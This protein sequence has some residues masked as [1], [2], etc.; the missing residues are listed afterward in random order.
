[1]GYYSVELATAYYHTYVPTS[2][3]GRPATVL[4]ARQSWTLFYHVHPGAWPWPRRT[5]VN[6]SY[7]DSRTDALVSPNIEVSF[8]AEVSA[9]TFIL[10]PTAIAR[11]YGPTTADTDTNRSS[12]VCVWSI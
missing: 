7:A 11:V 1:M 9:T 8:H 2:S 4:L 5:A 6:R 3:R 12:A 10:S